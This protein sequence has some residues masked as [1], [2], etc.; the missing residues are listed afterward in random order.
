VAWVAFDVVSV[1]AMTDID[2]T[3]ETAETETKA[4]MT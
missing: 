4:M 2:A 1:I 3:V